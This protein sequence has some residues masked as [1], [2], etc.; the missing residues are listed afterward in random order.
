[1]RIH[2]LTILAVAAASAIA[3]PAFA[4]SGP[5][6]AGRTYIGGSIGK[7]DWRRTDVAGVSGGSN[8][9]TGYKAY[10]GQGI[11]DNFALELGGVH[12]GHLN[13]TGGEAS[14]NGVYLDAVGTWPVS[15]QLA[16]LGRVGVVNTRL[17]GPAGN[18]RGTDLKAG[19]GL[20][21]SID[22]N[23][24]IRGEWE[25]YRLNAMDV[26]PSVDLYS[27]GVNYAF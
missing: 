1:M 21:Y 5:G 20:Q 24:S 19:L 22:R 8:S 26:K 23:T 17:S 10:I 3:L 9:G 14:A 18:G 4:Q 13:G 25:R 7:P 16:V 12:L 27:V 6:L 11:T 2:S 15:Q